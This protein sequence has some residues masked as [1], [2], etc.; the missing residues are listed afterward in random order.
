[1]YKRGDSQVK[2]I[3]AGVVGFGRIGLPHATAMQRLANMY[4]VVAIADSLPE[5]QTEAAEKFNCKACASCAELVADKDVEVVVIATPTHL[6][7]E[8]TITA[9]EAGKAVICDKPV[10]RSLAET[11]AMLA[12]A[13]RTGNMFTVYQQQRFAA[14]FLKVREVIDSGRLG[15]ITQ[16]RRTNNYFERRWDWQTLKEFGGGRLNNNGIHLL[17]QLMQLMKHPEPEVFC[18]LDL[19]LALGD[20]DD[21]VKLTLRAPGDPVVDMEMSSTCA[22]P[23][24]EWLVMGTLGTLRGGRRKLQ[25]K[26]IT[27][28]QFTPQT[29][30][31]CAPADR[32]FNRCDDASALP[33]QEESWSG[34]K[35]P[36]PMSWYYRSFYASL[37]EGAPLAVTPE[38]VRLVMAVVE[39]CHEQNHN[40]YRSLP[41]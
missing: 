34:Q 25:W 12:T 30:E 28:E 23:V 18:Q 33:W 20:A 13:K 26:Y 10:A 27:Q 11:D 16:I 4:E 9:L 22:Y 8:N 40:R 2:P 19:T 6:H 32:L 1:M 35:A 29:L 38:S 24:D 39:K 5:R 37:R 15:R 21:H 36:H 3:K 41:S 14:D 31:R 17:D 7:K